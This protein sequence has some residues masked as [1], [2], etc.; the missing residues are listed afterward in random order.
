MGMEVVEYMLKDKRAYIVEKFKAPT[1]LSLIALARKIKI[2]PTLVNTYH[3]ISHVLI[4]IRDRFFALENNSCRKALFE[5]AFR[6]FICVI[7]SD[8][9]YRWRFQWLIEEVVE[10]VIDGKWKPRT[11]LSGLQKCWNGGEPSGKGYEF[12][13]ERYEDARVV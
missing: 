1:M 7:E 9:Y 5:A 2:E 6:V 12:I 8:R 3:P 13:K 4:D 10:A 11:E